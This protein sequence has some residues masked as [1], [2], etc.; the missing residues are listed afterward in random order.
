MEERALVLA[1]EAGLADHARLTAVWVG[2]DS[3]ARSAV[4]TLRALE[5][6]LSHPIINIIS[7][8]NLKFHTNHVD[9]L[10]LQEL[11]YNK[12][13]IYHCSVTSLNSI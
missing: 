3:K 7:N 4:D 9:Y 8:S 1:I 6:T 12:G 13:K 11:H 2:A 5:F 10:P